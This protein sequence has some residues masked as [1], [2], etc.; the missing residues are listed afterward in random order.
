MMYRFILTMFS[1]W[2]VNPLGVLVAHRFGLGQDPLLIMLLLGAGACVPFQL[3]ANECIAV[4]E[5]SARTLP[6]MAKLALI[7]ATQTMVVTL[8]I[9][10]LP[11]YTLAS[12]A[13]ALLALGLAVNTAASYHCAVVY[14]RLVLGATISPRQAAAV[15][16]LPGLASLSVFLM[17][18]VLAI[19]KLNPSSWLVLGSVGLPSVVQLLYLNHLASQASDRASSAPPAVTSRST[20]IGAHLVLVTAGLIGVTMFATLLRDFISARHTTYAAI[21]VVALNSL[22]SLVNT[23]TRG[24]FL[25][26]GQRSA[27]TWLFAGSL[28][29]AILAG[30]LWVEHRSAAELTALVSS[31]LCL[32]AI[33]EAARR[34]LRK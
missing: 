9:L 12:P 4:G 15:G 27:H 28:A 1:S 31:Q 10:M 29:L 19:A 30:S 34:I 26:A 23:L 16:A 17:Y 22:T 2:L 25:Q 6:D 13:L 3:L 20:G 8:A 21:I 7:V 32:I 11:Q 5:A 24:L 18:A 14:Y 33:I